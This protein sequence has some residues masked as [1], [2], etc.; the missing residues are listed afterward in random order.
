MIGCISLS[1]LP[2][3]ESR[4]C[5]FVHRGCEY[6]VGLLHG[7]VHVCTKP[8]RGWRRF[9]LNVSLVSICLEFFLFGMFGLVD[10]GTHTDN[11][12]LFLVTKAAPFAWDDALYLYMTIYRGVLTAVGAI[13]WPL[14]LRSTAVRGQ[15]TL[16][17]AAGIACSMGV[18]YML[19]FS[20]ESWHIWAAMTVNLGAAM[21][22]PGLRSLLPRMVEVDE[23]ARLFSALGI[24]LLLYPIFSQSMYAAIYAATESWWPGASFAVTA[25]A[26]VIPL[27]AQT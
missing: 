24:L 14:L 7:L 5:R 3:D 19:A 12:L 8:R 25:T 13:A 6:A 4:R 11:N 18:Y 21:I 17:C 26:L 9:C 2:L 15:D 22:S 10:C 1:H 20:T 23:T 16:M 27:L